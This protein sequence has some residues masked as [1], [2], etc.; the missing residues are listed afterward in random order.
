MEREMAQEYSILKITLSMKDNGKITVCMAKD[1]YIILM[2][3]WLMKVDGIWMLFMV[4]VKCIMIIQ[5]K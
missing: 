3:N 4:K 2:V 1:V 5:Y